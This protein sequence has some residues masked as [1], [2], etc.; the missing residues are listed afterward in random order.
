[1]FTIMRTL[2]IIICKLKTISSANS[3]KS[4]FGDCIVDILSSTF[5]TVDLMY[6]V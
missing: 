4:D 5:N 3:I 2:L 6:E 1:M